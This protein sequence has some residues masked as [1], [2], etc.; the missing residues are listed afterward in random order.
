MYI[1][2]SYIWYHSPN[3]SPLPIYIP[4][5][6]VFLFHI[7]FIFFCI[8]LHS[9]YI[10]ILYMF[11]LRVSLISLFCMYLNFVCIPNFYL[12]PHLLCMSLFFIYVSIP[13]ICS[14]FPYMSLLFISL[15]LLLYFYSLYVFLLFISPFYLC[16]IS[17]YLLY[18]F[19]SIKHF[20][21]FLYII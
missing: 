5:S 11:N 20:I 18:I 1:F 7:S 16:S 19:P 21:H 6:L 10:L 8:Y 9:V 15:Y 4:I 14:H 12:C 17:L 2:I 3:L 13:S